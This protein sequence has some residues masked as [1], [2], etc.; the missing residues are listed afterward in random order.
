MSFLLLSRENRRE[1]EAEGVEREI[2]RYQRE[3]DTLI[4]CFLVCSCNK[5]TFI[6]VEPETLQSED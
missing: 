4:S 5:R 3:R 2:E 1:G 6:R